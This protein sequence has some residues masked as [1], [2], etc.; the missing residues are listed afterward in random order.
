MKGEEMKKISSL[1]LALALVLSLSLVM[2]TPVAAVTLDHF[3]CYYV[4]N[5]TYIDEQVYL[6]D[7]FGAVNATVLWPDYFCNPVRKW[8][9]AISNP[10]NHLTLY[11]LSHD[12]HGARWRV[13]VDNQFGPQELLVSDPVYLGVP[14]QKLTPGPHDPPVGLD[15][16]LVYRIDGGTPVAIEVELQD[17]FGL[18]EFVYV[19]CPVYFAN[20]VQK[21]H[22][23]NV[24]PVVAGT[25]LV[26]Y[27]IS[28]ALVPPESVV[29]SNQFDL[30]EPQLLE[31][32]Q[33]AYLLAV[34]SWKIGFVPITDEIGIYRPDTG[35][36]ALDMDGDGVWNATADRGTCFG[37]A[38]VTPIIGDWNGDWKDQIGIYRPDT[39]LFALDMDG[40]GVWNATA[41][42]G[43]CF[44]RANVTPIIGDWS[45]DCKDQIGIYRPDKGL[46][47]L[48][49]DGD[50]VWNAA[51]DRGTH[52]GSVGDKPIIGDWD[53]NGKDEIGIYRPDT[54]LFALDMDGDGVWNRAADRGTCFGKANVT[55]IIGD[56]NGDGRDQ[57]GIYRPDTGLFA[58]DMDGDGVWNATADRGT[59]FGSVG[60]KPIIGDWDGDGKDQIGIY[61]PDTGLFAL[62]M[63]GNGVWNAGVDRRTCFGKAN[64]TP[65]IGCW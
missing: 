48:D 4:W 2:A 35:L 42:R 27:W 60:D 32:L 43:T 33:P 47:A 26:F 55:P 6:E 13:Q 64:V 1:V 30:G 8:P 45:G 5:L 24:T 22:D 36:F 44:G 10:N 29:V 61:R 16:F 37:R 20:P 50:G 15:H 51:V 17:Q 57:I 58:L 9:G 21:T 34:P 12:E 62:D 65:I 38:N 46:F 53:G 3:K 39:G 56:W 25:E 54:G 14:T 7:Q 23:G 18:Q 31:G 52:F 40:D 49:M 11:A 41:D 59:C 63:N 28:S 19:A